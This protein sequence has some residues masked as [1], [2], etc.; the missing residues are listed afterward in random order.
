LLDILLGLGR[1]SKIG[2]FGEIIAYYGVVEAQG[3][4]RLHV[5]MLLWLRH[6][7]S[8]LE[9]LKRCTQNPDFAQQVFKWYEDVFSQCLP[10]NTVP[11]VKEHDM[12]LRQP[13]MSRPLNP[14]DPDFHL[15]FNQ[16]LR[17]VLESTAQ[18]HD[19]SDTCF[20]YLPKTPRNLR[21]NDKD[22][23]F[24]LPRPL[25]A[26]THMDEDGTIVLR[27]NNGRVNTY[28]P[29]IVSSER[30]NMD[31]K[32]IS[33]G[34]VALAMFYYVGNYTIKAS[35]DTAIIFSALCAA[36]KALQDHP[37]MD[38][39]G[40][41]D[42]SEH[43]RLL[44][45][46]TVNQLVGKREL[47]SQQVATKLLGLPMRYTNMSYPIF[48]WSRTLR[49]LAPQAFCPQDDTEPVIQSQE[50]DVESALD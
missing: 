33:S 49:E 40:E 11:Y 26:A 4:G 41:L 37:P 16:D 22:C 47:S 44:M 12:Y 9:L 39:D 46:K 20:K 7:L 8:P 45:V 38:V 35:M 15:N 17:E 48:Y 14:R 34:T 23:R 24:Q 18:I 5:H 42:P 21:D 19:H 25:Q 1:D 43:S 36:I 2:V 27:C 32:T 6:A 3:R 13:V 29:L 31:A 50:D 28:V 30:C 10:E